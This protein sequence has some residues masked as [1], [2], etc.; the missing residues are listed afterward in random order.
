MNK[1]LGF[2]KA[3]ILPVAVY[4][5]FRL[6]SGGTFG[7]ARGMLTIARQS[8][9][10][11]LVAW[12]MCM[13]MQMK[14]WD[15]S[16]GSVV[17][18]AGMLGGRAMLATNTG[19]AGMIVFTTL[20]AIVLALMIFL[21]YHYM[22]VPSIVATLGMLMVYETLSTILFNSEGVKVRG[23]LTILARSPYC[24][25]VLAVYG[26]LIYVLFNYTSIGYHVR[27]VGNN[28]Q[29]AANIGVS[30]RNTRLKSF[31]VEG[32]MLGMAAVI[33]LSTKGGAAPTS[34]M[35]SMSVSF[36]ALMSVYMGMF[37]SR[38]CNLIVGIL[39]GTV[40]M[41]MLNAGLIA[42]GLSATLQKVATGA[43]LIIVIGISSNQARITQF[44]NDRRR[45]H[46]L[47]AQWM[48]IQ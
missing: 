24:F 28:R 7:S 13:N 45:A 43:F 25:I 12:G 10:S 2:F 47:K 4:L 41:K 16:A 23:D 33:S 30:I 21:V 11:A 32:V 36:D 48:Q 9:L 44:F 1:V 37:L 27:T 38:Y 29:V 34:G 42:I 17:V 6:I 31:I 20:A 18:L 46:K 26:L 14:L 5:M 39:L 15:L 40:S 8:V 35:D 19:L 3:L 22:H